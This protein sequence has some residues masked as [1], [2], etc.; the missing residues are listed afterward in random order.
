M[1]K[2]VSSIEVHEV[3]E[4]DRYICIH[5]SEDRIVG[6]NYVQGLGYY[7]DLYDKDGW[8]YKP[9]HDLTMFVSAVI[10]C[11]LRGK[12]VT[13]ESIDDAIWAYVQYKND[14]VEFI[15]Y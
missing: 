3:H 13:I 7:D 1:V 8:F 9:D 14:D 15:K 10:P 2:L 5:R 6:L 11:L 12:P 4:S